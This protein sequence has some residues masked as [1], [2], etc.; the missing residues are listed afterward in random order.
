MNA[1]PAS[2]PASTEATIGSPNPQ[3]EDPVQIVKEAATAM[4]ELKS[5]HLKGWFS[6]TNGTETPVASP[7]PMTNGQPDLVLERSG[8]AVHTTSFGIESIQID[9]VSYER[10]Q[11]NPRWVK[12]SPLEV[13]P[14]A[15]LSALFLNDVINPK[16]KTLAQFEGT[17][18]QVI[19]AEK[20]GASKTDPPT[21]YKM[22]I[23]VSDHWVRRFEQTSDG[24]FGSSL[25]IVDFS[26]FNQ[27][28]SITAP[29]DFVNAPVVPVGTRASLN[30]VALTVT[31]IHDNFKAVKPP[32]ADSRYLAADV[33]IENV[34]KTPLTAV[35]FKVVDDNG[36]SYQDASVAGVRTPNLTGI[37]PGARVQGTVVFEVP[38]SRTIKA[39]VESEELFG[40][41]GIEVQLSP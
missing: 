30:G 23:G 15:P 21:N 13:T 14:T 28:I 5:V 4:D 32:S 41:A 33:T 1:A 18:C 31:A 25:A 10:S 24:Q 29:T 12:L 19:T 16:G 3:A 7:T 20:P 2:S 9:G 37:L 8:L 26:D 17:L 6:V 36:N 22:W 11:D 34:G 39:L 35:Y 27:P 40:S 38:A